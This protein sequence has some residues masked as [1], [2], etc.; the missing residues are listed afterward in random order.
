MWV[1]NWRQLGINCPSCVPSGKGD[2]LRMQD[3]VELPGCKI[4]S[5]ADWFYL[6]AKWQGR[7]LANARYS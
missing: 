4:D 3:I 5:G 6:S 2:F 1:T 7:L